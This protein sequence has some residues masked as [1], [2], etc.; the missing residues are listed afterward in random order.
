MLL[1]LCL[2][3]SA[4]AQS[5]ADL[6]RAGVLVEQYFQSTSAGKRKR[7]LGSLVALKLPFAAYE[8]L[9]GEP[10]RR[11]GRISSG[12]RQVR[13]SFLK[14]RSSGEYSLHV[15]SGYDPNK[16]A[17]L[18]LALHGTDGNGRSYLRWWSR[19]FGQQYLIA[20]PSAARQY[21]LG[22]TSYA[23]RFTLAVLADVQ[24]IA[25]VDPDRIYAGGTSM[26]AHFA[27]QLGCHL[28]D[29]FAAIVPRAGSCHRIVTYKYQANFR[30]VGIYAVNGQSDHLIPIKL[31][32]KGP[33]ALK[34]L[35]HDIIYRELRAG[36]GHY[37]GEDAA[38][39][40]FLAGRT[41]ARYPKQVSKVVRRI[42][43][44]SWAYWLRIDKLSRNK[45]PIGMR[46]KSRS[47]QVLEQFD[48]H[49]EACSVE[50]TVKGNT[51]T[52]KTKQISR[53]TLFLNDQLVDLNKSVR[54]VVN[55]R[56]RYNKRFT[57][58]LKTLLTS[59]VERGGRDLL[60]SVSV[61]LRP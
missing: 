56:T 45:F 38:I 48:L 26:G 43:F 17:P 49:R 15:P 28:A 4:Q 20:A 58:S 44:K 53:F 7:L 51:I 16:P 8:K 25:H 34:Q 42:T 54:I 37:F 52:I 11:Y 24:R 27:Y 13:F 59:C 61:P 57:R 40:R 1:A 41:R 12:N 14:K 21:G 5:K 6:Q 36:H 46:L 29:R 39:G 35:K 19:S 9:V 47:G 2:Y 50:G 32:R 31:A 18:I 33:Q 55:G 60:F 3:P 10:L 22:E 23:Y 30:N